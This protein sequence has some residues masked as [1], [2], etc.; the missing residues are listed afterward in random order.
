MKLVYGIG[1]SDVKNPDRKAYT[2]WVDMLRRCYSPPYQ[3]R[4]P[5]YK[6]C[7]VDPRWH[8]LSNFLQWH[9]NNYEP[10]RQLDKDLISPGNKIYG[11]DTCLY[12]SKELNLFFTLRGNDRG[13]C[14]VGVRIRKNNKTNPYVA[15]VRKGKKLLHVGYYPTEQQ[16]YN[17]YKNKKKELLDEHIQNE[18]NPVVKSQLIKIYDSI[19][20]YL[21]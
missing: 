20:E 8:Y 15:N 17:A 16:A 11:P 18:T 5:T 2:V 3:E 19:E 7:S 21:K 13:N 14:V 6:G 1:I 12:I 4:Y 9:H 10:G